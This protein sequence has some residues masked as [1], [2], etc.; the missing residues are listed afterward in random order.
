MMLISLRQK[1]ENYHKFII[2]RNKIVLYYFFLFLG[3][4]FV[5][6]NRIPTRSK[7]IYASLLDSQT[8]R[9]KKMA[10]LYRLTEFIN[11]SIF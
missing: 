9:D 7:N 10:F 11:T 5:K 2:L 1:K 4:Y 6:C 8:L 3:T